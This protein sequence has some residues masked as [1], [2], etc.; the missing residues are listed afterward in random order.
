M[1]VT[2]YQITTHYL[3]RSVLR[4]SLGKDEAMYVE[5]GFARFVDAETNTVT[6]DEPL[7][8]LSATHWINANYRSSYKYFANQI[9]FHDSSSNGFENYVAFCL[10]LAFSQKPRLN[11]VFSFCG[12]PP[13]WANQEVE[14]IALHLTE[15]GEVEQGCVRHS[16][17]LGPSVTLGI[18]AKTTQETSAWLEHKTHAP[19]CF[20]H[21]SMG[22]DLL[23]VV[24][25]ADGSCIWVALQ[26]KYSLG[27]NGS[28]KR[29][30]LRRAMRSV[31]PSKFFI[32]KVRPSFLLKTHSHDVEKKKKDGKRFSLATD[33]DIVDNTLIGL[34]ALPHR[35]SDAGKYSLLRVVASFPAQTHLKRCLEE[36]PDDEGHPIACLNMNFIQHL[37]RELSPMNFLENLKKPQRT[38]R[39]RK[40]SATESHSRRT[41][42][43]KLN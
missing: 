13:T 32:E 26:A 28:L 17:F 34:A 15:L 25:L 20:P 18:N 5:Y 12:S 11:E 7:I 2:I 38:T 6:V 40:Q 35:R 21:V 43:I 14:L 31:T 10:S 23:F 41:K 42:K 8:L 39:K 1:I 22:P 29:G 19:L 3:M 37:T 16:D 36:D 33:P 4:Q 27:K 30:F 9:E 24:R